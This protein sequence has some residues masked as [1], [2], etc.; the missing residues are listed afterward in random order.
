MYLTYAEAL[1]ELNG[2]ITD[3]QLNESLNLVRGRAGVAPLTNQLATTYSLNIL[4]EIRRERTVE[5]FQENNRFNDLKRWGIAEEVLSAPLFGPIIEGT[6][7]ETNTDL[8][9]P[10]KFQFGEGVKQYTVLKDLRER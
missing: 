10:S 3:G 6:D 8:Y 4:E 9:D 1:Y 5:L 2:A 7:Y